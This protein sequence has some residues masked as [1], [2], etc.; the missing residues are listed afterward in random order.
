MLDATRKNESIRL[1]I[2][3]KSEEGGERSSEKTFTIIHSM[4]RV[5]RIHWYTFLSHHTIIVYKKWKV[6]YSHQIEN[7][8]LKVTTMP[9]EPT[10]HMKQYT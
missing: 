10:R 4:C 6:K 7:L 1:I 3:R 2:T 5:R 8:D 9:Q